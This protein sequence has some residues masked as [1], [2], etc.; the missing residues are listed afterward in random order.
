MTPAEKYKYI[1][2]HKWTFKANWYTTLIGN[3]V[4]ATKVE[5]GYL[6]YYNKNIG[7]SPFEKFEV[8]GSGLVGYNLYGSDIIPLRGYEENAVTPYYTQIR[9]GSGYKVYNGNAYTRYYME[10]RYLVSPNPQATIY[11]L[12]FVEGGNAWANF[13]SFNPFAVKRSA[14]F[15]VRAFLPMFGMLGISWGYG[16]DPAYGKTTPSGSQFQFEMGQQF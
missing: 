5:F 3:L 13:D 7:P 6:G 12:S 4:M 16:F 10:F 15:G 1:E 14:G 11:V 8:G 9:N 2:F